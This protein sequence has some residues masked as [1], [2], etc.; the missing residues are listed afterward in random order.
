MSYA[1]FFLKQE[2]QERIKRVVETY[3]VGGSQPLEEKHEAEMRKIRMEIVN[4]HGE[5]VLLVNYSSINYTGLLN[6]FPLKITV[7]FHKVLYKRNL[8]H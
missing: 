4:F 2:L 8:V 3:G 7:F 1:E 6:H 5:M